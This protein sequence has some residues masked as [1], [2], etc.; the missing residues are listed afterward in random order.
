MKALNALL[1]KLEEHAAVICFAVMCIVVLVAVFLRYVVEYPFPWGEELARYLMI[2]GIFFGISIGTRERTH[3][4]VE[5][6]I[7]LLPTKPRKVVLIISQI[8]VVL[9]YLCLAILSVKLVLLLKENT[10]RTPSMR[11]P[12]F[13]IYSALPV[14]FILSFIRAVKVLWEDIFYRGK[15][16]Q[17]CEEVSA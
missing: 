14:G 6:F 8:I 5:A 17:G 1:N 3:L 12:F 11:I 4:G 9:A 7:G 2:W 15:D 10:Q 13:L 16:E